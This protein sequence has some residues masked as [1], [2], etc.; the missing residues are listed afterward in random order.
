ML[1][2]SRNLFPPV[3]EYPPEDP[4]DP[5]IDPSF[6]LQMQMRVLSN[7]NIVL[8][9]VRLVGYLYDVPWLCLWKRFENTI[10]HWLAC[11]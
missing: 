5:M 10:Q 8:C 6:A 4:E 7:L 11:G 9:R 3:Y 2:G 1:L